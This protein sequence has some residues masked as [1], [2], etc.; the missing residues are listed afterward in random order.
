MLNFLQAN[1][2]ALFKA[3]VEA[4]ESL[5]DWYQFT[6]LGQY[7]RDVPKYKK[8]VGRAGFWFFLGV[9]CMALGGCA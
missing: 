1:T 5:D 4:Y 2:K 8:Y 7:L 3:I 9:F 6:S